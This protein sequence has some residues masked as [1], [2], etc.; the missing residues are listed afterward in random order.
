MLLQL[1]L[2]IVAVSAAGC[3]PFDPFVRGARQYH[4]GWYSEARQTWTPL[5][6]AGDC[7]AQVGLGLL[8]VRGAGVQKSYE[9]AKRW[10]EKAANQGNFLAQRVL[11]NMYS[12]RGDPPVFSCVDGCGVSRDWVTAYKWYTLASTSDDEKMREHVR[13]ALDRIRHEM[14]P[15]QIEAAQ[16]L[17]RQWT[18][19]PSR[20]KP[21]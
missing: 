21:R 20:C 13:K 3:T 2:L 4:W 16:D 7:N 18:P 15:E 17:V 9:E 12:H 8:Y 14:T 5:A 19:R 1:F 11:G 6:E 10:W